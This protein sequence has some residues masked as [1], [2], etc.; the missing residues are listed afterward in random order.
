MNE[1]FQIYHDRF[2]DLK[3]AYEFNITDVNRRSKRCW[4]TFD[5]MEKT[6]VVGWL[7]K[8]I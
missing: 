7:Y 1:V 3:T 4:E 5:F 8:V 6:P 2:A